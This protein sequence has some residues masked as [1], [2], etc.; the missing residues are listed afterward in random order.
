LTSLNS[1]IL[2][3]RINGRSKIE[4]EKDIFRTLQTTKDLDLTQIRI[5]HIFSQPSNI[6]DEMR[7]HLNDLDKLFHSI[8]AKRTIS[9]AALIL[10]KKELEFKI[11]I[12]GYDA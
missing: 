3:E 7:M 11:R 10:D 8:D 5:A 6:S 12:L 4:D 2:V 1:T 9:N